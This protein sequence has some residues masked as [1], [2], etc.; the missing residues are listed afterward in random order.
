MAWY[1]QE[2]CHKIVLKSCL[3]RSQPQIVSLPKGLHA[4]ITLSTA[5]QTQ[6]LTSVQLM[7]FEASSRTVPRLLVKLGIYLRSLFIL[8]SDS[9]ISFRF[10][11]VQ[12]SAVLA[13]TT[14]KSTFW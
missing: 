9:L 2:V 10:Q 5:D 4:D 8:P 12:T 1:C 7:Y 11:V 14:V 13:S 3:C 6:A